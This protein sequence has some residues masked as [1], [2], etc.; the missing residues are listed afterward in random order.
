MS[1]PTAPGDAPSRPGPA[2][3]SDP[4][5]VVEDLATTFS[6]PRGE[7]RAVNGVSL[8]IQR[9]RTLGLVGESGS[10]KSVLSRSIMG[11]LPSTAERT[12]RVVFEGLD[13]SAW[14]DREYR[15]LWGTE[16]AMIFQD[17]MTALN[18][19]MKIG[20]QITESLRFHLDMDKSTAR[21]TAVELL[22][23]VRIPEPEKRFGTYPHQMSGGM[24]Q[25]VVIAVA[26]A[27]GPKLLFAD[28]PTTALD[29]TVQAQVMEVLHDVQAATGS[30]MMLITHDLGLVAG[31]ADRV[32]VMYA[33]RLM[34]TGSIDDIFY[35][36]RN[37]YTRALLRS[38]PDL[39]VHQDA[40]EAIPGN[41]PSLSNPPPGCPFGPRCT[42]V[43]SVCTQVMPEL[44]TLEEE[45][46]SRCHRAV[47]IEVPV[48][49]LS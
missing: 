24:R 19:V 3:G 4:V 42:M 1:V 38:I 36:S 14:G 34:E 8:S 11:L 44:L 30:A 40:L 45:H 17:P 6:S 16:M 13:I 2:P 43:Q 28:E 20:K 41:P 25:R 9:G 35:R 31:S 32:Q 48:E 18:P 21:D 33:S 15:D 49:V 37:P 29:V 46:A 26:L 5:L 23:S 47:E 10:G 12:G 22:R 7:V 39:E 27:C